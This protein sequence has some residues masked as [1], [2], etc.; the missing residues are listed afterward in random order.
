MSGKSENPYI[1]K[2]KNDVAWEYLFDKYHVLDEINS[3]GIYKISAKAI[4]EKR[5]AR[6]MTKFDHLAQLP[7]IFQQHKLSIQPDSRSTYVIGRFDS[8]RKLPKREDLYKKSSVEIK[9][10]EFPED[11][12]TLD[13]K[14]I[15]SEATALLCAYN[16][17]IIS[18]LLDEQEIRFTIAGRMSTGKF[19]YSINDSEQKTSYRIDVDNSQ[20]EIDGGF[21]GDDILAIIEAKNSSVD[22]FL[23]RQLFYPYKLWINKT[24]KQ[25]IPIFLS[26]FDNIFSF[27]VY[28][29]ED[30]ENYNSITLVK[31][32]RYYI[33]SNDIE[34][35]EIIDIRTT[36][37]IKP[38]S[39]KTLFPQADVFGRVIDLLFQIQSSS[40][41]SQKD[42]A[43]NYGFV[44]RQAQYYADAAIYLGL[45]QKQKIYKGG[46]GYSLTQ[47]GSK[48]IQQTSR[49]RNLAFVKCIL[50]KKVF[51]KALDV[52]INRRGKLEKEDIIEIMK[53]SDI[54]LIK[55]SQD[56]VSRRADTV[57]GWINWIVRLTQPSQEEL[58]W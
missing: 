25:V 6:L 18:D 38:E 44:V 34:L 27:Y 52:Y 20:C 48:I 1:E 49:E 58:P 51:N 33:G 46:V 55:K 12:Q 5:E 57:R 4:N 11:I 9:T 13:P 22:N 29:F 10:V 23:I 39:S 24:S 53:S 16:A 50:E 42:I 3:K 2:T 40:I 17:G 21:E 54:Q 8:Y 41:F 7:K 28:E 19:S 47:L 15:R 14:N 35:Q 37:K 56:T 30:N 36:I 31:Q 32:K 45:I 43:I 26:Y